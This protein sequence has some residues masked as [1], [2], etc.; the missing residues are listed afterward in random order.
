MGE[1]GGGGT[2]KVSLDTQMQYKKTKISIKRQITEV[3]KD[4]SM[5][6]NKQETQRRE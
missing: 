6:T 3:I 2:R 1:G 5:A 4:D